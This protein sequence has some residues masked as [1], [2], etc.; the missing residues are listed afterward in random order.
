LDKDKVGKGVAANLLA[1]AVGG[2]AAW[3]ITHGIEIC[4]LTMLPVEALQHLF[5][6]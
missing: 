1:F 4:N 2:L 6:I 5:A 3:F